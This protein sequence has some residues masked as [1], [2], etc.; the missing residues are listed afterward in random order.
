MSIDALNAIDA[1]AAALATAS[2]LAEDALALHREAEALLAEGWSSESGCAAGDLLRQQIADGTELVAA[3]HDAAEEFRSLRGVVEESGSVPDLSQ[4]AVRL[5]ERPTPSLQAPAPQPSYAGSAAWPSSVPPVPPLPDLAGALVGLVAT[6]ADAL[7]PDS[8][9]P[10]GSPPDDAPDDA[11]VGPPA[12]PPDE[13]AGPTPRAAVVGEPIT[14]PPPPAAVP[15]TPAVPEWPQPQPEPPLLAAERPPE[16]DPIP[17]P[18]P[19]PVPPQSPAEPAPPQS[20]AEQ[21][22]NTPCEIAADELPQVGQ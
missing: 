1:D 8:V 4:T 12:D 6:A 19:P 5:N 22:P 14:P 7:S 2:M 3:L 15:P 11:P 18:E 10:S 16:S 13:K 20:P 9:D 21:D 17:A